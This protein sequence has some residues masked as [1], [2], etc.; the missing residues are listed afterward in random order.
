[1]MTDERISQDLAIVARTSRHAP[2]TLEATLA[3]A[4]ALP[5][6]AAPREAAAGEARFAVAAVYVARC[7]RVWSGVAAVAC[8]AALFGLLFVPLDRHGESVTTLV[9]VPKI[10][11]GASV[12]AVVLG[13]YVAGARL[14]THRV[15]HGA[16][17]DPQVRRRADRAGSWAIATTIAGVTCAIVFFGMMQ[18]VLGSEVLV[19]LVPEPEVLVW[20]G[21]PGSLD[22]LRSPTLLTLAPALAA[23]LAGALVVGWRRPRPRRWLA[24]VGAVV[25]AGT[26]AAGLWLDAGPVEHMRHPLSIPLRATLTATGTAGVFLLVTGLVLGLHRREDALLD[27]AAAPRS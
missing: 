14:A 22:W 1:M 16:L 20:P 27:R 19:E 5:R 7:A 23:S 10:W 26:I 11:V 12:L 13:A 15:V 3:A 24:V 17:A 18:V 9:W 4:G 25:V 2:A 6:E 21:I 8:I